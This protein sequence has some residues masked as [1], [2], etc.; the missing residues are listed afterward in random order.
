LAL[1][2]LIVGAIS[3]V[4]PDVWGN[5]YSVTNRVLREELALEFLVGVFFAKLL[6]TLATV[7]SGAVGGVFTPTLF[8]GAAL[9]SAFVAVL[10]QTGL[11]RGLPTGTFALVGMGSVLAATTHSP[12]LA[13]IM[14]FE[15][16]LNYSLMPPLMIACV[17]SALVA[18]RLHPESVYTEPLRLETLAV[19]RESLQM[20]AAM[21]KT[22]A[23]LMREPVPPIRETATFRQIADR[24]LSSPN[25]FLPVVDENQRLV[26]M[27][28]L[29][30][31]KEYLNAG[32][33][34]NGVIAYDVMRSPPACLTPNQRLLD[35]LP[36]LL[37]SEQRNV[38]VINSKKGQRLVGSIAR[39]EVLGL[40]SEALAPG[41]A[42]KP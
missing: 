24:F 16:S 22:V 39:V 21:Q 27:V 26:G 7:G 20:G 23:D 42:Q 32:Q 30:D 8:L 36:V 17:V 12:L 33:E 5:G 31:L 37:A 9:G 11:A 34:L 40:F 6:A 38:P 14:V 28:A 2:G 15:I 13:M 18:R 29:Q 3:V 19:E 25:N 4:F 41:T 10:H 1:G 35:T